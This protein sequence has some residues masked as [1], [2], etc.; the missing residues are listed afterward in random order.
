MK[1][2]LLVSISE[3]K[4]RQA[5]SGGRPPANPGYC[6]LSFFSFLFIFL[7]SLPPYLSY[8]PFPLSLIRKAK[9]VTATT[10][11]QAPYRECTGAPAFHSHKQLLLSSVEPLS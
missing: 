3:V 1:A 11:S 9:L 10:P 8:Y 4:H 5:L 7:A 6:T 2:P